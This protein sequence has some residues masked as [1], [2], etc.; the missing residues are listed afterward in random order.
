MIG[1]LNPTDEATTLIEI[2]GL[3]SGSQHD[4]LSI[5]GNYTANGTLV[6]QFIDGFSPST[7]DIFSI[8]EVDGNE[9]GAFDDII[10]ENLGPGWTYEHGYNPNGLFVITST[11]NGV[12][13]PEPSSLTL[14]ALALFTTGAVRTTRRRRASGTRR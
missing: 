7:G 14:L 6:L 2:G 9:G 4:R 11:S 1:N 5:S 3:T 10:V 13:V 12:Y 8:I